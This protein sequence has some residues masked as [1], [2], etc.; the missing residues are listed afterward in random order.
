MDR[1]GS[2]I[3]SITGR[4]LYH[5]RQFAHVW[6][7]E[8]QEAAS[9]LGIQ[10]SCCGGDVLHG[11]G[12]HGVPSRIIQRLTGIE[13]IKKI[14][15]TTPDGAELVGLNL[16]HLSRLPRQISS[17]RTGRR[18]IS[19]RIINETELCGETFWPEH[20]I[21]PPAAVIARRGR[22][23]TRVAKTVSQHMHAGIARSSADLHHDTVR[24]RRHS[25]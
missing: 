4:S 8:K 9:A 23:P 20:P 16:T 3:V 11:G 21:A 5:D 25:I 12:D 7:V 1:F 14:I 24:V 22:I 2:N 17:H 10:R 13:I 15:A 18:E 19:G 6:E